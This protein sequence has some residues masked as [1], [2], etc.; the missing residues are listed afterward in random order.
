MAKISKYSLDNSVSGGD[1]VIGTDGATG[2]TKNFTVNELGAYLHDVYNVTGVISINGK[3]GVVTIN[4]DD[5]PQGLTNLYD[6]E[7]TLTG[8]GATQVTGTYPN[9]TISSTDNNT[10]Y[11]AGDGI[12]ILAGEISNTK[13][14]QEV[15]LTGYGSAIVTGEYPN[16][17]IEVI[18]KDTVYTAGS[19]I[20]IDANN[21]ITNTQQDKVVKI[22]GSGATTVTGTYPNF[23]VSSTDTN[24]LY[25]AGEN[26]EISGNTINAIVPE[27]TPYRAGF[28]IE[29]N[30]GLTITNSLPG[31]QYA[32]GENIVISSN[33]VISAIVPDCGFKSYMYNGTDGP[34]LANSDNINGAKS[35]V[36]IDGLYQHDSTYTYDGFYWTFSEA[37]P[38]SSII[39]I[40]ESCVETEIPPADIIYIDGVCGNTYS[41]G[42]IGNFEYTIELGPEV[43]NVLFS[44]ESFSIPDKFEVEY[45]NQTVINTGYVGDSKYDADLIA[46]GLPPTTNG[47]TGTATFVKSAESPSTAI[48]RVSAPLETT[49]WEFRLDCPA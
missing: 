30:E 43:G 7:V 22:E 17:N 26:I 14:D 38:S 8:V 49:A 31:R 18:D 2:L 46:L 9:F 39:N 16:F 35:I 6:K 41:D 44:Y 15:T 20:S 24:T 48:V 12:Q 13:P 29:I 42:T 21:V 5:I 32:A 23:T 3:D 34:T 37:I 4:T 45:N 11:D 47:P 1:K 10:T 25:S 19:G 36:F 40:L 28:G 33:D 27:Q